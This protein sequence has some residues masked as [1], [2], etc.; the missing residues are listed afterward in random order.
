MGVLLL[1]QPEFG[2]ARRRSCSVQNGLKLNLGQ[3]TDLA[4][5]PDYSM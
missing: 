2:T 4:A 3:K 5:V 1:G